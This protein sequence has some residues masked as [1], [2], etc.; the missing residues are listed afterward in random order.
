MRESVVDRNGPVVRRG[1]VIRW[2]F[3]RDAGCTAEIIEGRDPFARHITTERND[4]ARPPSDEGRPG[5]VGRRSRSG[6][7][8]RSAG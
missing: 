2:V 4:D 3:S 7:P 5:V 6:H 8:Q 1:R